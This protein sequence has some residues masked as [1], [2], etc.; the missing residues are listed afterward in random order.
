LAAADV[1][2]RNAA[3]GA[4]RR[5]D[6]YLGKRKQRRARAQR[7]ERKVDKYFSGHK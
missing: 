5:G 1:G 4:T 7:D 6:G 3:A 2:E